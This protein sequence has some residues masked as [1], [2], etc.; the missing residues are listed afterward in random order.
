M[1]EMRN[2]LLTPDDGWLVGCFDGRK[3]VNVNYEDVF[4]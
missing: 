4:T 3:T 2:Q 1:P